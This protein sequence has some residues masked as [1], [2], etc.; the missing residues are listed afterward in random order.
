MLSYIIGIFVGGILGFYGGKIDMFGIAIIQIY[1]SMPFLFL[2]MIL[3][4]FIKPNIYILAFMFIILSGWVGIC[5]YI[6]G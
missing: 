1:S 2:L 3:G 4:N 5:W 6:R